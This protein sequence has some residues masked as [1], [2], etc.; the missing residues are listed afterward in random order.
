MA[1]VMG[2]R[3]VTAADLAQA[4]ARPD[5]LRAVD[6]LDPSSPTAAERERGG[7]TQARYLAFLDARSSTSTLGFRLDSAKTM[8][9]GR[10]DALPLPEGVELDA[11]REESQ[12]SAAIAK[13]VQ[14]DTQI[15]N[16]LL[17]KLKTLLNA[18]QQSKFF[19][20]H[21]LLRTTLLCVYDDANHANVQIRIMN[22]S[23]AYALPEGEAVCHDVPW[24]STARCHEDGYLIGVRSLVRIMM[25]LSES[26]QTRK[27]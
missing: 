25:A 7:L 2:T 17:L 27:G 19:P 24:D 23:A 6:E 5:L 4:E 21:A 1:L 15:A 22:F 3:T 11:L 13:F 18:L 14:H 16:A 10:L 12:V 26:N 8:V 20:K 9:N